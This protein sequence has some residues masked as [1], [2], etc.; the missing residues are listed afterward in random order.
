M[1]SIGRAVGRA[2]CRSLSRP[3]VGGTPLAP[4]RPPAGP[5]PAT[6]GGGLRQAGA[7][8]LMCTPLLMG[9]RS[10][11]IAGRK[12]KADALRMKL[13]GRMGKKIVAVRRSTARDARRA[14]P[15]RAPGRPRARRCAAAIAATA[16]PPSSSRRA[17]FRALPPARCL[18]VASS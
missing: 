17:A 10:A 1:L 16:A 6:F 15:G 4:P 7:R 5:P 11:K 13:Y 9:R 12:G 2:A 14:G 3:V 18:P 8:E